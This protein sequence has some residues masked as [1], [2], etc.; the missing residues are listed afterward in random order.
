MGIC[1]YIQYVH[2]YIHTY[3]YIYICIYNMYIQYV[4]IYIFLISPYIP[5]LYL[6]SPQS[7]P[8]LDHSFYGG[9]HPVARLPDPFGCSLGAFADVSRSRPQFFSGFVTLDDSDS[10]NHHWL[11]C[12]G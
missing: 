9:G 10:G 2:T 1:I 12:S 8:S 5:S 6:Q 3:I 11:H 7:G 4:Y